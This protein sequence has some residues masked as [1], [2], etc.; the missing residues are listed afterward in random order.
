MN[1]STPYVVRLGAA[2][3]FKVTVWSSLGAPD[4][5]SGVHRVLH[6]HSELHHAD[7]E[8][9]MLPFAMLRGVACP[10]RSCAAIS[11][12]GFYCLE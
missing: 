1:T 2:L 3:K 5:T 10:I 11:A 8:L 12:L 6:G 7:S 9:A 4:G